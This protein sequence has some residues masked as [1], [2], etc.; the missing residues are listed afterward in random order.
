MTTN[1]N[2]KRMMRRLKRRNR[3]KLNKRKRSPRVT[4]QNRA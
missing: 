4:N 3:T 2:V 1:L